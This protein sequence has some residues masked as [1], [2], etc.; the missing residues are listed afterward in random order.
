MNLDSCQKSRQAVSKS[1]MNEMWIATKIFCTHSIRG[2]HCSAAAY[3]NNCLYMD[4]TAPVCNL[5]WQDGNF[6]IAYS[7]AECSAPFKLAKW[8]APSSPSSTFPS[9]TEPLSASSSVKPVDCNNF[10]SVFGH[11]GRPSGWPRDS[12]TCR[13]YWAGAL[14]RCSR[15]NHTDI[16]CANSCGWGTNIWCRDCQCITRYFN[17]CL[18]PAQAEITADFR[19]EQT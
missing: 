10:N 6:I 8:S 1:K 5:E 11:P 12:D 15:A 7:S 18:V 3:E 13:D 9:E 4:P 16:G 19:P 2:E 17:L 14:W